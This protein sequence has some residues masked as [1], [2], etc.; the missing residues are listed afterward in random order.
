MLDDETERVARLQI[1]IEVD[2]ARKHIRQRQRK[3]Q[4]IVGA[5]ERLNE[6]WRF[7]T[8]AA[9]DGDHFPRLRNIFEGGVKVVRR[10]IDPARDEP[11]I[12]IDFVGEL[13]DAPIEETIKQVGLPGT[14]TAQIEAFG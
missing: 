3:L 5:V 13:A 4:S 6:R 7:A 2:F 14:E 10:G 1:V 12:A 11:S 8:D 9:F